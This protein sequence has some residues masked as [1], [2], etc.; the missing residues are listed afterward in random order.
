MFPKN[1]F[2]LVFLLLTITN[3]INWKGSGLMPFSPFPEPGHAYVTGS[4]TLSSL[5]DLFNVSSLMIAGLVLHSH[6]IS[7][8]FGFFCRTSYVIL[9]SNIFI[10]VRN[11]IQITSSFC[12]CCPSNHH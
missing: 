3:M 7:L 4:V 10:L 1:V 5:V 9:N 8:N 12:C 6:F 2:S 11:Y